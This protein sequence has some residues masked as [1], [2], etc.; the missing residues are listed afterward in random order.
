MA[1]WPARAVRRGRRVPAS[2]KTC[3][4]RPTNRARRR[5]GGAQQ[6]PSSDVTRLAEPADRIFDATRKRAR[7]KA[8]FG[9]RLRRG[10]VHEIFRHLE[11]IDGKKRLLAGQPRKRFSAKRQRIKRGARQSDTRRLS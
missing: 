9:F 1:T 7:L 2:S 6:A 8:Q 5:P 11:R 4:A 10:K 3:R